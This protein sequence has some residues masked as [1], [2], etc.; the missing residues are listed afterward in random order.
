M[1]PAPTAYPKRTESSTTVAAT[2]ASDD[3]SPN[4]HDWYRMPPPGTAN[5]HS[6]SIYRRFVSTLASRL[7]NPR[8]AT[9]PGP[10]NPP[11]R[12]SAS[13]TF[14]TAVPRVPHAG[15]DARS[16]SAR[17]PAEK[18]FRRSLADVAPK[19]SDAKRRRG[20]HP[21][22]RGSRAATNAENT[23]T[24]LGTPSTSPSRSRSPSRSFSPSFVGAKSAEA[25]QSSAPSSR[26]CSDR[27]LACLPSR[28]FERKPTVDRSCSR[29]LLVSGGSS[30]S[31]STASSHPPTGGKPGTPGGADG[32]VALDRS[33]ALRRDSSRGDGVDSDPYTTE[34]SVRVC[35]VAFV[36]FVDPIG[37]S[38]ESR[39]GSSVAPLSPPGAAGSVIS[40]PG[41][42]GSIISPPGAAGSIVPPLG[43]AGSVVPPLAA[44]AVPL[45][46]PGAAGSIVSPPPRVFTDPEDDPTRALD[47]DSE[48][49]SGWVAALAPEPVPSTPRREPP[50]TSSTEMDEGEGDVDEDIHA[51]PPP[52]PLAALRTRP[53]APAPAAAAASSLARTVFSLDAARNHSST[54]AHECLCARRTSA[55]TRSGVSGATHPLTPGGRR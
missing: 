6:W 43:A 34:P 7:P 32:S 55:S 21:L 11:S 44:N 54:A 45:S 4:S 52:K 39:G 3:S 50:R 10:S 2:V 53:P 37:D 15:T 23:G 31:S 5:R 25:V 18:D 8:R 38:D 14:P 13:R 49:N 24:P 47:S 26:A 28:D 29:R 1:T 40:P 27:L 46:P 19:D 9:S 20:S 12:T 16:R 48:P 22:S 17:S 33:V 42:A 35:T 41:A 30:P 36:A 51:N